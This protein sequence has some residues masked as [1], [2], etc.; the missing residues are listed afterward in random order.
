[1]R[2]TCLNYVYELAKQDDRVV[3][4]GSDLGHGT[5]SEMQEEMPDR[6]YMEG[7]CESNVVGMAAG[8]A[9][10]GSI[11]YINTIAPFF[12]RRAMDQV[13]VDLCM[14]NA[15]V[16]II[17]NGGGM[18][19]SPL[20]PT[21]EVIEDIAMMRSIPNMTVVSVADAEEMA[22][23]MPETLNWKGP[24]YIRLAKGFDPIVTEEKTFEIGKAFY[25]DKGND[26]VI[27][28]T[29]ITRRF[30]NEA[31]EILK[32]QGINTS[33]IHV[34]TI[35][36]LDHE[37][38]LN[39]V[40]NKKVIVTVEEHSVLGGLGGAVSEILMEANFKSSKKF[41]RL[42]VPDV[43]P[44]KYGTQMD[45]CHYYGLGADN[46]VKTITQLHQG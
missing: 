17:A 32:A 41:K 14:H 6:F 20:G 25:L 28:T 27:I 5:L 18:V 40:E 33:L 42:G 4:I 29:G 46:I 16:R 19:Y 30:A 37:T 39:G 9:M 44:E 13:L 3:F 2:K 1:M 45:L 11:V 43:F 31:I 10:D 26:A 22:R 38:I 23:F 15:N 35:K 34:P 8:M 36:P 7:I 12:T 21:H 24:I